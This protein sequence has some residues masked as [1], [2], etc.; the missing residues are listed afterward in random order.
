MLVPLEAYQHVGGASAFRVAERS[1]DRSATEEQRRARWSGLA[2]GSVGP[3]RGRG[4]RHRSSSRGG[5]DKRK[6]STSVD[7]QRPRSILK[8]PLGSVGSSDRI[9]AGG[10]SQQRGVS[11]SERVEVAGTSEIASLKP[12]DGLQDWSLLPN[13]G[14]ENPGYLPNRPNDD[15]DDETWQGFLS[16][17]RNIRTSLDVRLVSISTTREEEIGVIKAQMVELENEDINS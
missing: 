15:D 17:M 5:G 7:G 12:D 14:V 6:A 4:R 10:A 2:S 9:V 16:K 11:L 3:S 1:L 13:V 8:S